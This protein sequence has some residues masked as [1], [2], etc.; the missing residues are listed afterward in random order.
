[1]A[2]KPELLA[3]YLLIKQVLKSKDY[4]ALEEIINTMIK[5]LRATK[6]GE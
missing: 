6:D 3:Q 5:E 4:E 1:M 2:S